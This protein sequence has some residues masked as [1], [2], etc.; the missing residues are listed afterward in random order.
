MPDIRSIEP[1]RRRI[2]SII[3]IGTA[4]DFISR[5][6]DIFYTLVILVNLAV[7]IAYTFDGAEARCGGLL[8]DIEAA[9]VAF[10]RRTA[11]CVSGHFPADRH[12]HDSPPGTDADPPRQSGSAGGRSGHFLFAIPSAP[13]AGY[14]NLRR[15]LYG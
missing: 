2:C 15:P 4:D 1:L 12:R 3:D 5:A 6:Y 13:R 14:F 11:P 9:T 10:L 7:T 8:L